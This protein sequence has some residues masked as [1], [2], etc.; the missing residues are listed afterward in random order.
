VLDLFAFLHS[1][2]LAAAGDGGESFTTINVRFSLKTTTMVSF[3]KKYI[4][5]AF[6][7]LIILIPLMY[8]ICNSLKRAK[9]L[10]NSV[11]I[12]GKVD[13]IEY[14]RGTTYVDV[15]YLYNGQI[16]HNSFGT[17]DREVLDSLKIKKIE[18]WLRVSK[19]YPSEYIRYIGVYNPPSG[20]SMTGKGQ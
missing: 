13:S 14:T 3:K 1:M 10:E 4:M 15:Q 12:V 16:I 18:I 19:Q 7:S 20:A 5:W 11:L 2:T 9:A 17:N 8:N 6:G